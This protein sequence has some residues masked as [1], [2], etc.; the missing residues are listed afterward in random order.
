M[1]REED[2]IV[3]GLLGLGVLMSVRRKEEVQRMPESE[4]KKVEETRKEVEPTTGEEVVRVAP[5]ISYSGEIHVFSPEEEKQIIESTPPSETPLPKIVEEYTA[6]Q[7]TKGVE[8][9]YALL[10][11]EVYV[12]IPSISIGR[13]RQIHNE[14]YEIWKNYSDFRKYYGSGNVVAY[15]GGMISAWSDE[16]GG[17]AYRGLEIELGAKTPPQLLSMALSDLKRILD[18]LKAERNIGAPIP[19][20]LISRLESIY[21]ELSTLT[22]TQKKYWTYT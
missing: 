7:L 21:N 4:L 6:T 12:W 2:Y 20:E 5:T 3:L 1:P 15:I 17:F 11:T 16:Y 9:K 8:E 19:D 14:L 18:S 22:F 10:P 13:L